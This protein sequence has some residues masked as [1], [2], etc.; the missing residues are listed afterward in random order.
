M[1]NHELDI[2]SHRKER[3]INRKHNNSIKNNSVGNIH[4]VLDNTSE[5]NNNIIEDN[6]KDVRRH[7]HCRHHRYHRHHRD[8]RHH[9][10]HKCV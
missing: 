4:N 2:D 1:N 10:R 5:N 3:I 9:R 7:R 8:Y 6:N